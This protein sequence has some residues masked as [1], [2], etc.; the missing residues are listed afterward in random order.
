[1]PELARRRDEAMNRRRLELGMTWRQVAAAAH[2]SYETLRA[3]RKGDTAGGE[4]TLSS[5]ERALR[6][7]P[8]AFA[9]VDAGREPLPLLP[10]SEPNEPAEPAASGPDPRAEAFLTLLRGE[11]P[12]VQEAVARGLQNG[13]ET[14]N[15]NSQRHAG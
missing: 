5:I 1:M 12:H 4:L 10:D 15:A 6:W 9:A 8:G 7:T 14:T 2:I 11:P 13:Q 3:V